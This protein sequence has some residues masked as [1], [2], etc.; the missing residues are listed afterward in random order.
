MRI[1]TS[2]LFAQGLNTMLSQQS[3]LAQ[4]QLQVATGKRILSPADDPAGSKRVLD[5]N[6]T[7]AITRQYQVNA[8]A[9][10]SR[11]GFEESALGAVTNIV[12]RVRELAIQ[13]NNATLSRDDRTAIG[14]EVQ[15]RL[16]E[17]LGLANSQD[18]QGEFLFAGF[19]TRTKPFAAD[20]AGNFIYSGDQGQR[21]VQ[22]APGLLVADG[23]NGTE[24]FQRIRNGNGTFQTSENLANAGSGVIDPGSVTNLPAWVPDTYTL[25][26]TSATDYE[27]RDSSA[28]LVTS[29]TYVDGA[30]IAFNGIQTAVSG[31]PAVG[32]NFTLSPST[33]QDLFTT[34]DNLANALVG[35]GTSP[36]QQAN[37]NNAINRVLVDLDQGLENVLQVRADVGARLN[38]IESERNVNADME[39]LIAQNLS[40]LENADLVE[41]ITR[42][43]QQLASLEAAQASFARLQNLSLFNFL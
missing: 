1:S 25:T 41:V 3:A 38:S 8:D 23:N 40:T 35:T 11:I 19:S 14:R 36:T 26:F 12:H 10:E 6:E 43:N 7:L 39:L 2:Q 17:L 18:G 9:A 42:L 29:G 34:L 27:V 21:K 13:G 30:A 22:I 33:H 24:V 15:Q 5:L 16:A 4:T 37:L 20:G 32:D 31:S 28:A